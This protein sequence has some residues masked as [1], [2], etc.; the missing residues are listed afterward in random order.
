LFLSEAF[1]N[2]FDEQ[3]YCYQ[4]ITLHPQPFQT[5]SFW[6]FQRDHNIMAISSNLVL[7]GTISQSEKEQSCKIMFMLV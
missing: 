4:S 6:H 2:R 3:Q 5:C 1:P 7:S